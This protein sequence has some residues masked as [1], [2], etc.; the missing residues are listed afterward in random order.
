MSNRKMSETLSSHDHGN[1]ELCDLIEDKLEA[2]K[3]V[4]YE[5]ERI[6]TEAHL[7]G[8]QYAYDLMRTVL[9]PLVGNM[10]LGVAEVLQK[11]E[12]GGRMSDIFNIGTDL[13]L[14]EHNELVEVRADVLRRFQTKLE[15]MEHTADELYRVAHIRNEATRLEQ[16]R[17]LRA[18]AQQEEQKEPKSKSVARRLIAQQQRNRDDDW[19]K[20]A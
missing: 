3:A 2:L 13:E 18:A 14:F 4:A 9:R 20:H 5:A 15:A 19:S 16:A 11:Q 6:A 12:Q 1:C 17:E 8:D 7:Q 10:E